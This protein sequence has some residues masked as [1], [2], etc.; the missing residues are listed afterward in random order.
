[1]KH[2]RITPRIIERINDVRKRQRRGRRPPIPA[3]QTIIDKRSKIILEE[4]TAMGLAEFMLDDSEEGGLLD[5]EFDEHGGP[6]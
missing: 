6:F 4:Y 1:M 5:P 3:P 2:K